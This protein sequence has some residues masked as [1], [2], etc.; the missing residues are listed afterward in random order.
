MPVSIT[1]NDGPQSAPW[2]SNA[3]IPGQLNGN[4]FSPAS[5]NLTRN[6]SYDFQIAVRN[7][8]NEDADGPTRPGAT[9]PFIR[10][11]TFDRFTNAPVTSPR[12]SSSASIDRTAGFPDLQLKDSGGT[13]IFSLPLSSPLNSSNPVPHLYGYSPNGNVFFLLTE[14][15]VGSIPPSFIFD[16]YIIAAEAVGTQRPGTIIHSSQIGSSSALAALGIGFVPTEDILYLTWAAQGTNFQLFNFR[17]NVPQRQSNVVVVDPAQAGQVLFSPS[18]D[19]MALIGQPQGTA[20]EIQLY[21][22]PILDRLTWTTRGRPAQ[23]LTVQLP[24]TLTAV[25]SSGFEAI[26]IRSGANTVRIDSPTPSR[27]AVEVYLWVDQSSSVFDVRTA[28]QYPGGRVNMAQASGFIDRIAANSSV[29]LSIDAN[30]LATLPP[31]GQH[32]CAIAEA[33]TTQ[34]TQPGDPR[35]RSSNSLALSERQIAQR[36]LVVI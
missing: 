1:I 2:L 25:K 18:G 30:W 10:A 4:M 13:V 8:G 33:F 32:F 6:N 3:V 22:T 16:I 35:Q 5:A 12:G 31:T 26:E 24:Y 29:G 17:P 9:G 23:Q 21:K 34:G 27:P 28:R 19:V 7:T 15:S 11:L 20:N 14:S 36:N